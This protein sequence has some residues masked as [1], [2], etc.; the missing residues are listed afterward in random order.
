VWVSLLPGEEQATVCLL[1][2]CPERLRGESGFPSLSCSRAHRWR[3]YF[4]TIMRF[5]SIPASSVSGAAWKVAGMNLPKWEVGG[6]VGQDNKDVLPYLVSLK[7][8]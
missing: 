1:E 3:P 6:G 5:Y 2:C 7:M 8:T 4:A